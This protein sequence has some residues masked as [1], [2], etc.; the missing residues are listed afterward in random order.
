MIPN[1]A[2]LQK[3]YTFIKSN[4]N[5]YEINF[6]NP[7]SVNELQ[8]IEE[9]IRNKIINSNNED[10]SSNNNNNNDDDDDKKNNNKVDLIQKDGLE[11]KECFLTDLKYLLSYDRLYIYYDHRNNRIIAEEVA[12]P[13]FKYEENE[14]KQYHAVLP[15]I[16]FVPF[17]Q[18][19]IFFIISVLCEKDF[20]S[21][22]VKEITQKYQISPSTLY[23]WIK[24]FS[25]YKNAY[26]SIRNHFSN[27]IFILMLY[28]HEDIIDKIYDKYSRT[29]FQYDKKHLQ[30]DT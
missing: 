27:N 3:F 20:S 4:L 16:I 24:R 21:L 18:Y 8:L 2:M 23:R 1:D 29:L 6:L 19:S 10:N 15:D 9:D 30:R 11:A 25:A 14:H 5:N 7:F 17:S 12:I 26:I 22:T 13:V 28:F